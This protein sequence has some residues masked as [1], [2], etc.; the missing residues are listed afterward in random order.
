MD[1]YVT[2]ILAELYYLIDE[3]G[4]IPSPKRAAA[5]LGAAACCAAVGSSSVLPS[6]MRF[7]LSGRFVFSAGVEPGCGEAAA[8]AGIDRRYRALLAQLAAV[9]SWAAKTSRRYLASGIIPVSAAVGCFACCARSESLTTG[10]PSPGRA[11]RCSGTC[12]NSP[13][14]DT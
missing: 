4:G 2:Q 7:T 3:E 9:S 12:F 1:V 13:V 5:L 10:I 8:Q 11:S 14:V 6:E